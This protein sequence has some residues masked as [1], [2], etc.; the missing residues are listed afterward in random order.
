MLSW[1]FGDKMGTQSKSTTDVLT[2]IA[3]DVAQK[4]ISRCVQAATQEQMIAVENVV[5]NVEISGVSLKQGMSVN[6]QCA[7]SSS[8]QSDIQSQIANQFTQQ[9]KAEGIALLSALGR[10]DAEVQTNVRQIFQAHVDQTTLQESVMQALQKQ[11]ITVHTVGGSA[12]ISNVTMEQSAEMVATATI[13]STGYTSAI[14]EI[15]NKV[16][17]STESKETGPL[18]TFFTMVKSAI[19]SWI[20]MLVGL[21]LIGGII[22]IVFLRYLFTTE[23]G[24]QLVKSGTEIAQQQLQQ[25]SGPKM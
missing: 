14:T 4:N 21:A 9:A 3:L 10:T 8:M 19:S 15:A 11:A 12:I 16:D 7:M 6:M 20:F 2:S 13:N 23:T 24:A 5:G 18:D 17:Q 22:L 1:L 25:R